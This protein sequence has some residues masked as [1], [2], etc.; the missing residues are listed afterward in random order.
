MTSGNTTAFSARNRIFGKR[1]RAFFN[2]DIRYIIVACGRWL[3]VEVAEFS[4]T[5][6][7]VRRSNTIYYYN[8]N[9]R[10]RHIARG[11]SEDTTRSGPPP[12]VWGDFCDIVIRSRSSTDD[13]D[14]ICTK[15]IP[16]SSKRPV[17]HASANFRRCCSAVPAPF[18]RR[19]CH[20]TIYHSDLHRY[21]IK[22]NSSV[23]ATI[24]T[25][26][27]YTRVLQVDGSRKSP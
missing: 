26:I 14:D 21:T 19:S 4:H 17:A 3:K 11:P 1:L 20:I 9:G 23:C 16:F 7:S 22:V 24:P 10:G 6:L 8:I 13:S 15:I 12:T 2:V 25:Y 27:I 5:V 18:I